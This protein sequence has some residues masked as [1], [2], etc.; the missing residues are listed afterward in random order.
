M[1]KRLTTKDFNLLIK[2]AYQYDDKLKDNDFLIVFKNKSNIDYIEVKCRKNN[3]MHLTGVQYVKKSYNKKKVINYNITYANHFYDL[4]MS[5]RLNINHCCYK[6]D[7][8]TTIKLGI[9][10]QVFNFPYNASMI[11]N[12]NNAKPQLFTKKLCGGITCCIGFTNG[13]DSSLYPN[14]TLKED[15]RKISEK[16]Y[17]IIL[18]CKKNKNEEKYNVITKKG[19]LLSDISLPQQVLD[20][21]S[22]ELTI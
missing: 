21:I 16:T 12:Y 19:K 2:S 9:L 8:T 22:N 6:P 11:G 14:T 3:F 4:I 7:G 1:G 18:I 17:P 10:N 5:N 20:L 13:N 15:I